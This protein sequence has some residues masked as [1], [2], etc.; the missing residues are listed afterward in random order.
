MIY[1]RRNIDIIFSRIVEEYICKG[2]RFETKQGNYSTSRYDAHVDLI[3]DDYIRILPFVKHENTFWKLKQGKCTIGVE[4]L[5]PRRDGKH[6][7]HDY[8]DAEIKNLYEF[9]VY[10]N[11]A[12][13]IYEEEFNTMVAIAESRRRNYYETSRNIKY[14]PDTI[15]AIVKKRKGYKRTKAE[16][17]ISVERWVSNR[18]GLYY[19]IN[20]RNKESII[21][22]NEKF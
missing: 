10:D 15:L 13:T 12:Y 16:D 21:I 2:A 17:I 6:I 19:T 4:I 20:I 5:K 3:T 11:A 14:N 22:K 9:Y 1:T 7:Y 8:R 18:I